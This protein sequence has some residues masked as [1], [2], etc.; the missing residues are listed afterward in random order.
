[1]ISSYLHKLP[2]EWLDGSELFVALG[3]AHRQRI[4]LSFEAG[5]R[6]NVG[7]IVSNSTLSRTA[8][9]HHLQVLKRAGVLESEKVGKEVYF[10]INK[11]HITSIL[12]RVLTYVEDMT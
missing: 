4:L 9:S 11:Q 6:L 1:M 10:W 5:E 12:Q 2:D 8:I 3:D 7:Q